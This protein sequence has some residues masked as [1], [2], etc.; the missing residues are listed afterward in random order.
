MLYCVP[1]TKKAIFTNQSISPIQGKIIFVLGS[2]LYC[3]TLCFFYSMTENRNLCC[4][5]KY[6]HSVIKCSLVILSRPLKQ[7]DIESDKH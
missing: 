6:M 2:F 3:E 7:K 1:A 5:L 4:M